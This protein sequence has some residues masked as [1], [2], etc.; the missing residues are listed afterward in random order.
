MLSRKKKVLIVLPLI[1]AGIGILTFGLIIGVPPAF[2]PPSLEFPI[3]EVENIYDSVVM[4][5]R[6]GVDRKP[7]I[8]GL[9]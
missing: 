3:T 6:I 2:N 9:T 4:V 5:L 8:T 1:L 7:I